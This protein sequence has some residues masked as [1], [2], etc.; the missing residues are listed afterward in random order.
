MTLFFELNL[1][2][3]HY[4][5]IVFSSFFLFFLFLYVNSISF[6]FL[7]S[8]WAMAASVGGHRPTSYT[9]RGPRPGATNRIRPTE[10]RASR[11]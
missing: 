2:I 11:R 10:T 9:R 4:S 3:K 1:S 6:F 8:T 5:F 7:S